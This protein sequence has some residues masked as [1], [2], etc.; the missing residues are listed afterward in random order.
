MYKPNICCI[1][2]NKQQVALVYCSAALIWLH[3]QK[4]SEAQ[5]EKKNWC[6]LPKD[7][8]CCFEQIQEAALQKKKK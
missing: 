6:E 5:G 1:A 3:Q 7:A 2:W 4:F 8:V